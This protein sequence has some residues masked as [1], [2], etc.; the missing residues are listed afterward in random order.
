VMLDGCGTISLAEQP[1]RQAAMTAR[2]AAWLGMRPPEFR[3][4]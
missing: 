1:P 3:Q 2:A 4:M